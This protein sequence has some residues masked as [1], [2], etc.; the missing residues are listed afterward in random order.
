MGYSDNYG[1][2]ISCIKLVYRTLVY[3]FEKIP[4]FS[5]LH[6]ILLNNT[7]YSM[8]RICIKHIWIFECNP[9]NFGIFIFCINIANITFNNNFVWV[10]KISGLP[11]IFYNNLIYKILHI[12]YE[13]IRIEYENVQTVLKRVYI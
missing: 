12:C 5:E 13:H 3:N 4:N 10:P 6:N 1:I 7:V 8:L 9:E 11:N 2:L